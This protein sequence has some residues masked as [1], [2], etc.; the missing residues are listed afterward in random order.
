MISVDHQC[1]VQ[2]SGFMI[3]VCV[4]E[5]AG[6]SWVPGGDWNGLIKYLTPVMEISKVKK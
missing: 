5:R 2:C 1:H 4:R 3:H 6:G